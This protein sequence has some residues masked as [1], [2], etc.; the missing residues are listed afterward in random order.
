[1]NDRGHYSVAAAIVEELSDLG[2]IDSFDPPE[3]STMGES[4]FIVPWVEEGSG[5]PAGAVEPD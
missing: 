2:L 4:G 5:A 3:W 1:M